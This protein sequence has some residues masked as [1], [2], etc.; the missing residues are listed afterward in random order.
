MSRTDPD[1][2]E[3]S[4]LYVEDEPDSRRMLSKIIRHR[5][6]EVRLLVSGNGE[7]GL[8][9]FKQF[10]PEV[11]ITDI[12]MPVTNGISMA[13]GIKSLSPTTEIIAL[14]AFTTTQHLLQAIEIGISHYILKPINLEHVFK[15]IDTSLD[16]VRSARLI[17]RQND[18]IR[19][20]NA[21]LSEKAAELESANKELE[22]FDYTV[23]HDLRSPMAS[24]S[25]YVQILLDMHASDLD[26]DGKTCLQIIH[27]EVIRMN[28][29]VG[30]LLRFSV[31][32]RKQVVKKWTDISAL[33]HEIRDDLQTKDPPRQVK[34]SIAEGVSGYCDPDLLQIVLEN[35]LG[36]AWKYTANTD[37][38]RIEFGTI[39]REED[40]VY[41]VRDNGVGFDQQDAKHL[42]T[43]FQRLQV[44]NGV[45]GFGIG[46][47]TVH[48]IIQR[49]GGKIWAEGQ[50]ENGAIFSF[51]I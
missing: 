23:A 19:N 24:I 5:Y 21:E 4:L 14:T 10:K 50:N 39:N 27:R 3:I 33:V 44:G 25:G 46:L 20:L 30:T 18:L 22:S 51:T 43:P 34:F 36:N 37:D 8:E 41:F 13:T 29:L 6:P 35:L 11:V 2:Y 32:S 15:V 1:T 7:E 31:N 48:R 17:D 42:F 9:L 47:A 26:E 28:N 45:E 16:I 12:N 49:H 40:L 38:A